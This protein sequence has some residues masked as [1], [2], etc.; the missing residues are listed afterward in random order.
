MKRAYLIGG[1]VCVICLALAAY[2]LVPG[3]NHIL[4]FDHPADRHIKHALAFFALA[5]IALFG[6]RFAANADSA[7]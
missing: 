3:V 4:V 7:G 5:V 2:Y 1:I 6:A